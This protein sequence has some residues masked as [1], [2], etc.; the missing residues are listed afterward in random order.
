MDMHGTARFIRDGFRHEGGKAIMAEGGL[1]DE[2][3]EIENLIGEFDGAAVAE[4]DFELTGAAFLGDAV[5]L[6]PLGFGEIVDVVDHRAE[7]VDRGHGIR[8][9]R[10][11]RAA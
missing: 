10:C 2:A 3:L 1:A 8:L 7:F 5:D 9:A 6:E 11:G 4:V